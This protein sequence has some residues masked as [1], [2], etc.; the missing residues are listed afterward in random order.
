MGSPEGFMGQGSQGEGGYLV[1]QSLR[2]GEVCIGMQSTLNTTEG[3]TRLSQGTRLHGVDRR[4]LTLYSVHYWAVREIKLRL[5]L[6]VT[7]HGNIRE[8]GYPIAVISMCGI[9]G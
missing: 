5:P 4:G 6:G 7:L 9:G 3:Q 1:R 2:G 8:R